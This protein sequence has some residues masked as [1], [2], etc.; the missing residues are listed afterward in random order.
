VLAEID[1][2][3]LISLQTEHTEHLE[4]VANQFWVINLER[5]LDKKTGSFMDAAAVMKELDL[6]I[7][8]DTSLA[9]LAGALGVPTWLALPYAADW[10]WLHDRDDSPWYPTLRLFRQSERNNWH[11]VFGRIAKEVKKVS[12]ERSLAGSKHSAYPANGDLDGKSQQL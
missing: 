8:A 4:E 12:V 7:T 5:Q 11:E 6:V 2:V 1:G 10:R 3:Q 9:H